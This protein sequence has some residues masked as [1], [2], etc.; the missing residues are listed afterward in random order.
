MQ[1]YFTIT[2]FQLRAHSI[3]N[4]EVLVKVENVSKKFCR[5]L[6]RSLWY[7]VKEIAFECIGINKNDQL[8]IQPVTLSLTLGMRRV[9]Q[10]KTMMSKHDNKCVN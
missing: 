6:K 9:W 2:S 10:L 1:K 8:Q 5:D 4:N 3:M 7:G